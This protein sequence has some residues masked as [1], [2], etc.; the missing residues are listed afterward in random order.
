MRGGYKMIDLQDVNL[1]NNE[2]H[3][4]KG[5]YDSI[6]SNYRKTL[7]LTGL[8]VDDIEKADRYVTFTHSDNAYTSTIESGLTLTITDADSVTLTQEV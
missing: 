1:T 3:T 6:E 2:S 5:I 7:L 8:T 4:I